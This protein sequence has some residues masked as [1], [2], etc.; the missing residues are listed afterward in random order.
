MSTCSRPASTTTVKASARLE[1]WLVRM[2]AMATVVG[3]VGADSWARVPPNRAAKKP[4]AIA[5]YK[6]A[7]APRPDATPKANATGS[8]TTAEVMP[9][10]KSPR[11]VVT[12]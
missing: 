10:E 4:T 12:F 2:T 6:P 5:P 11:S 8:V 3:A 7:A 9:P 1:E